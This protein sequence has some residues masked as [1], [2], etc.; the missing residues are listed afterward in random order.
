VLAD[1]TTLATELDVN[2]LDLE[3]AHS[4]EGNRGVLILVVEATRAERM[5]GGLL[6][7][8]YRPS[9]RTLE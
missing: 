2:I 8:G 4:S 5:H 6:A 7:R 1:V 9:L 3:I